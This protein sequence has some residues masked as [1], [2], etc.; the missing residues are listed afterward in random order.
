[1]AV[2][3]QAL[4][5]DLQPLDRGIN[6][7][8]GLAGNAFLAQDIPRLDRLAQ[9]KPHA[10]VLHGAAEWETKLPLCLEPRRIEYVSGALEV[11]QHFEKIVPDKMFEHVAVVQRRAPTY[12]FAIKR[13]APEPGDE[14]AQQQLLSET[15]ARVGDR[16]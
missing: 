15:H 4:D 14:R 16:K 5:F 1:M 2:R 13:G 10:G 11:L 12:R 6:E 9:F 8:R 7:A 3:G